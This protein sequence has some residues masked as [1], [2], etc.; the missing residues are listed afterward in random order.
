M[1][2][3]E[4]FITALIVPMLLLFSCESDNVRISGEGPV[5]T[6]TITVPEFTGIDLAGAANIII[7]QGNQRVGRHLD[8]ETGRRKLLQLRFDDIHYRTNHQQ[9][10]GQWLGKRQSERFYRAE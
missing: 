1:K 10:A 7:S 4:L 5:V 3:T 2:R 6:Q 9:Y 8:S